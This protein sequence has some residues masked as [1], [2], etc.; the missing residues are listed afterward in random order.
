MLPE[1]VRIVLV[2]RNETLLFPSAHLVLRAGDQITLIGTRSELPG[3]LQS[4][5]T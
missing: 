1:N 3:A 4:F 2:R 5:R